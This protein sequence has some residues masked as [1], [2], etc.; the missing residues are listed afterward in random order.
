METSAPGLSSPRRRGSIVRAR[1]YNA[2]SPPSREWLHCSAG[3]FRGLDRSG[4]ASGKAAQQGGGGLKHDA[5][6]WKQALTGCHPREKRGSI[7][8]PHGPTTLDPRLR[9]DDVA[10]RAGETRGLDRS[11]AASGKAARQGGGG[12]KHDAFT[13]KQALRDCHPREG[14]DPCFRRTVLRRWIPAFAGMTLQDARERRAALIA[15][16]Q[17]REKP[18][19]KAAAD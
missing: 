8:P 14:G 5:F 16:A 1:S 9:G 10:G 17:H 18:R 7:F 13:R 12:L 4:A 6:T 2:G 11:G 15:Q 19:G 3:E